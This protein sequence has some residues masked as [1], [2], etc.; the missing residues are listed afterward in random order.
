MQLDREIVMVL[1]VEGLEAS[2]E[3]R[4][5]YVRVNAAAREKVRS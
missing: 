5:G 4:E 1:P 2:F 3:F